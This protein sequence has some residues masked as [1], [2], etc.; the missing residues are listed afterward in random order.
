[1]ITK[2]KLDP[3]LPAF[4]TNDKLSMGLLQKIIHQSS[5]NHVLLYRRVRCVL[6]LIIPPGV[7]QKGRNGKLEGQPDVKRAAGEG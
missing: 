6:N 5:S 7:H 1:M 4:S 3:D 2:K